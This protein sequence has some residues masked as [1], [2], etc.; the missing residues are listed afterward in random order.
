[1]LP[2]WLPIRRPAGTHCTLLGLSIVYIA[3]VF[4]RFGL[5]AGG[6]RGSCGQWQGLWRLPVRHCSRRERGHSA[7]QGPCEQSRGTVHHLRRRLLSA[8]KCPP[9]QMAQLLPYDSKALIHFVP[10]AAGCRPTAFILRVAWRQVREEYRRN[11]SLGGGALGL[12]LG[13]SPPPLKMIVSVCVSNSR[14]MPVLVQMLAGGASGI[15][16][17]WFYE[18]KLRTSAA[19]DSLYHELSMDTGF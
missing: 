9:E 15:G 6:N 12:L 17:L 3:S 19:T 11:A 7:V 18:H 8:G 4:T 10:L 14:L 13:R 2:H 1:M 16:L 5:F